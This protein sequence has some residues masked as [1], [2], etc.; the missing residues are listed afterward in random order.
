MKQLILASKSKIRREILTNAGID[1]DIR[2]ANVDEGP[3]KQKL[4]ENNTSM[5]EIAMQLASAKAKAVVCSDTE[6]ILGADQIMEMDGQ[7]FDKPKSM[8]EARD[9]LCQMRNQVHYLVGGVCIIENGQADWH[10]HCKTKLKMRD[11]SDDFLDNYMEQEG[12]ALLHSVGAYMFEKSGAQL[13][14][15]VEGDFF[16]I[17]GLPL[18]P[19]L[20]HLRHRGVVAT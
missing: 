1:H 2:S 15:W 9:R 5:P 10:Y 12:E 19:V 13:F 17:L 4:L 14:E 20:Q 8:A 6:I 18:L 11:F 3:I 7:L 16:A